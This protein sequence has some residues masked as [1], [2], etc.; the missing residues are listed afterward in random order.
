MFIHCTDQDD[1]S[2]M[3]NEG[4]FKDH[5]DMSWEGVYSMSM[6]LHKG[7]GGQN[8]QKLSTWFMDDTLRGLAYTRL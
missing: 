5:V 6:L 1:L 8:G 3:C 4:S 2:Y 7:G